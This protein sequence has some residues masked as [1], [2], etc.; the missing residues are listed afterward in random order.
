[1]KL[2]ILDEFTDGLIAFRF[3]PAVDMV[4]LNKKPVTRDVS[5][6]YMRVISFD[7]FFITS[8]KNIS[9]IVQEEFQTTNER[10]RKIFL[11]NSDV[12]NSW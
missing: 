12:Y 6:W 4:D 2:D 11:Q 7:T 1:M 9:V 5:R 10:I 8:I 3:Q